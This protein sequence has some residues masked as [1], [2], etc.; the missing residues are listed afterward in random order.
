MKFSEMPYKRVDLEEFKEQ[1]GKIIESLQAAQSFEEAVQAF[2]DMEKFQESVG[3][4]LSLAYT[5]NSINIEDEFYDGE[6]NYYDE[7]SPYMSEYGDKFNRELVGSKFRS[8]L[9]KKFG[10]LMFENIELDLKT[11]SPEI[12]PDLQEENRLSSKYDELMASAQIEFDGKILNRSQ[13]GAYKLDNDRDVRRRAYIADAGFLNEKKAELDEIFDK[14]VKVRTKMAKTLGFKNF[15]ELG[16]CRMT[17]NDYNKDNVASFR[18]QVKNVLVPVVSILKEQQ[19]ARLGTDEIMLYDN[20]VLF[21]DGNAAPYGTPEEIMQA[22][23]EMYE[24]LSP[25]T[26]EFINFMLDNELFDVIAKKGKKGGGYCTSFPTYKSPFIFSNFNGTSDDIDV[27]THE[28]GHAFACYK[29]FD[30]E[31][32][33]YRGPT[34]ESCEI[35]SMAMEFFTWDWMEKFFKDRT[36][37]YKYAHLAKSLAFITYGTIV[38]LYQHII[39][40]NPD[41]TPEQRCEEWGELEKTFRPWIEVSGMPYY[42][43]NRRWQ[44][45]SHIYSIPFYYIDYCLAQVVALSF[46]ALMQQG[47]F[48]D[49]WARYMKII[50]LAGTKKFT[51][52]V[53]SADLPIPFEANALDNIADTVMKWLKDKQ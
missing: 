7:V 23:R 22:G 4:M 37:K 52:L 19:K 2:C 41:L 44:V 53:K 38:D 3:T 49:A 14:L 17:R 26:S 15:V 12:I 34:M 43:E 30:I 35:H 45:Q 16:Y 48:K 36:D 33:S 29:A 20:E 9:E 50:E 8:E 5:R 31:L 6:K 25:E 47:D 21:K 28:A 32:A 1:A 51:E 11:F 10:S 39:Y 18:E 46:W 42:E 24:E 27:L 40:E 13:L